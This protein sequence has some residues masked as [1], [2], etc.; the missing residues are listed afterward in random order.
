MGVVKS[1]LN[2][3][4]CLKFYI[5][6]DNENSTTLNLLLE[7]NTTYSLVW[8]Y[9]LGNNFEQQLLQDTNNWNVIK[10]KIITLSEL[11]TILKGNADSDNIYISDAT[12]IYNNHGSYWISPS[13]C[14]SNGWR[15]ED[16]GISIVSNDGYIRYN[17]YQSVDGYLN[18]SYGIRP[19]I[20]ISK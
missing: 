20:E 9:T 15:G 18:I 8:G 7:H 11:R 2:Q 1:T 13:S 3:T 16:C 14:Y 17:Y 5:F 4:S 10:S 12:W 6:L 19:V